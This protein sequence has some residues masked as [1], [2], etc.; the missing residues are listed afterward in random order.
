MYQPGDVV[1]VKQ[2]NKIGRVVETSV[3]GEQQWLRLEVDGKPLN[4]AAEGVERTDAPL[5]ERLLEG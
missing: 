1:R 2:N 5:R 3:F 4:V